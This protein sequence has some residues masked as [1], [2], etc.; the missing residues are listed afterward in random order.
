[1]ENGDFANSGILENQKFHLGT[2]KEGFDM[3]RTFE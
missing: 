3:R 2:P 1:M